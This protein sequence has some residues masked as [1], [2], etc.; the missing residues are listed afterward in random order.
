MLLRALL[1]FEDAVEDLIRNFKLTEL[2]E[3]NFA[4]IAEI[5]CDDVGIRIESRAF[6]GHVVGYDHVRA[7]ARELSAG[8]FRARVRFSGKAL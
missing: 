1:N 4:A 5:E 7:L 2:R 6:L 3:G 8:T